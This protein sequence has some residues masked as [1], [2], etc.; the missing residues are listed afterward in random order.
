MKI[1]QGKI[2]PAQVLGKADLLTGEPILK[3]SDSCSPEGS[4]VTS[5]PEAEG[6][7]MFIGEEL[8]EGLGWG[9]RDRRKR[10]QRGMGR[11]AENDDKR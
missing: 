9:G 1:E 4:T 11:Q 2:R 6:R 7:G 8:R 5:K 10:I 3:E